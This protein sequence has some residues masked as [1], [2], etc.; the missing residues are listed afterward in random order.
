MSSKL[1]N[2]YLDTQNSELTEQDTIT[3]ILRE[4][5]D[6]DKLSLNLDGVTYSWQ[7]TL[8]SLV[9]NTSETTDIN[10]II[11][12]V[13]LEGIGNADRFIEAQ[14]TSK[15]G[16]T[17][18]LDEYSVQ[19]ILS[20]NNNFSHRVVTQINPESSDLEN[21]DIDNLLG[22]VYEE[23][24]GADF[25]NAKEESIPY[26][27]KAVD[28]GRIYEILQDSFEK[29]D[30]IE[31]FNYDLKQDKID[32]NNFVKDFQGAFNYDLINHNNDVQFSVHHE[33][34]DYSIVFKDIAGDLDDDM[35]N[36]LNTIIF[37]L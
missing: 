1:E 6:G 33:G 30:S 34:N 16:E 35:S 37:K 36:L 32:I 11:N 31:I 14:Y 21:I 15:D 4:G 3:F 13:S 12:S 24:L 10:H 9:I 29:T 8:K 7:P 23:N 2:N 28:D 5:Q 26:T 27:V 18:S 22:I 25:I 19:P 17:F 20:S